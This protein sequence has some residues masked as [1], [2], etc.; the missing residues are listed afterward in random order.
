MM[1]SCEVACGLAAEL[2]QDCSLR[3]AE[4]ALSVDQDE[5]VL[6]I[7]DSGELVPFALA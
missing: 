4:V 1:T 6:M 7:G 5:S 2:A 3:P